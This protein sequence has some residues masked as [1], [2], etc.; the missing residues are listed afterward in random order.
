MPTKAGH[1]IS[2]HLRIYRLH[3]AIPQTNQLF[4]ESL[5]RTPFGG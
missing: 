5:P 4:Y 1:P 3:A 2:L